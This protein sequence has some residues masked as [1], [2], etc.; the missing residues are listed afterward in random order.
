SDETCR[1]C[2][3][4]RSSVM[5]MSSSSRPFLAFG[6][7]LIGS[8]KTGGYPAYALQIG[9]RQAHRAWQA[10]AVLVE[11]FGGRAGLRV[12]TCVGGREINRLPER[13][14]LNFFLRESFEKLAAVHAELL[15]INTDGEH[16]KIT[17]RPLCLSHGAESRQV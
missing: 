4:S 11:H 8:G 16:P 3:K 1:R 15:R 17:E 7:S 2:I 12:A 5:L 13:A 10:E 14:R 9:L 6:C